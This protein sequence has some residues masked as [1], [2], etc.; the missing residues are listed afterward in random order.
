MLMKIKL[1]DGKYTYI[2]NEATGEQTA[3]RHGEE[4]RDLSGDNL[5]LA[6]AYYIKDL[7]EKL[8]KNYNKIEYYED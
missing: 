5:I 6:M 7:E 4:W 3:L 8:D 2:L 1:M